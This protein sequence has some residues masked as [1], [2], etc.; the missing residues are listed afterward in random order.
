MVN[1]NVAALAGA[2]LMIL[3][4]VLNTEQ[5]YAELGSLS[6]QQTIF[7]LIGMMMLGKAFERESMLT[8]WIE[9]LL[10]KDIPMESLLWRVSIATAIL[11]AFITNDACV[12]VLTPLVLSHFKT[13]GYSNAEM[14]V[15]MIAIA[16]SAN[17]GSAAT[18]FGNPQVLLMSQRVHLPYSIFLKSSLSHIL[19]SLISVSSALCISLPSLH[20]ALRSR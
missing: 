4:G 19:R 20:R 10:R 14:K 12:V 17:I 6:R 3:F 18:V 9:R 2:F 16:T 8:Y 1:R 7:L 13:C 11:A 15:V 5:V